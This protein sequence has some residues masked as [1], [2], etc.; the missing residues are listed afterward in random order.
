MMAIQNKVPYVT[1]MAAAEATVEGI[2][3]VKTDSVAPKAL[4]DYYKELSP[5][6]PVSADCGKTAAHKPQVRMDA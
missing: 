4:Q 5:D 6:R 1:S 2:Q 3:A